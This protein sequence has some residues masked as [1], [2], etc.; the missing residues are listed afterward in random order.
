MR[1]IAIVILFISINSYS[2]NSIYWTP[3]IEITDSEDGQRPKIQLLDDGTPVIM[4]AKYMLNGKHVFFAKW[5]G[6]NFNTPTQLNDSPLLTYDWGG[7]EMSVEGN[8]I[9]VIYKEENVTTGRVY[10]H[11][12]ADAGDNWG[13][14]IMVE[15]SLG[16]LAM[17]PNVIA[18]DTNKVLVTYMTH[19]SGG[20]NPQYILRTSTDNGLSFSPLINGSEGFG[21]EAC[22]CCPSSLAV[23]DEMAVLM[24]R[25][26][27]N[28]IR[29]MKLAY[30]IDSAAT[31]NNYTSI[32]DW[33]WF[34]SSCPSS[35]ADMHIDGTTIYATYMSSG[36]GDEELYLVKDD[37]SNP[38][39]YEIEYV[40]NADTLNT[41]NHPALTVVGD[42]I[43]SVW[44]QST[45]DGTDLWYNF[46]LSNIDQWDK[47]NALPVFELA[48]PQLLPDVV[49]DD[50]STIHLVYREVNNNRLM[51]TTGTFTSAGIMDHEAASFQISPN[52]AIDF[53]QISGKKQNEIVTITDITG[54]VL[55][56][57][58]NENIDIS[59]LRPGNYIINI[60][61]YSSQPIIVR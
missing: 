52:P 13:P 8:N 34:Y 26:D 2:Q 46:S 9:Y 50:N 60:A 1:G 61:G 45:D 57:T 4:F 21:D 33:N 41:V 51:Y 42:T 15:D 18:Y 23:S 12:S 32:D 47:D 6:S 5:N 39:P 7:T 43:I 22:Y 31:F 27:A 35:N 11:H 24:F 44:Q 37:L 55:I 54:K 10:L 53:I 59:I 25:N 30:S 49:M 28:G 38:D 56:E 3:P 58:Q 29:E 16:E 17:Y 36:E 20:A 19:L 14:K 40:V 48:G